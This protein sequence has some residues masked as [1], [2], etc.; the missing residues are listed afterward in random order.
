MYTYHHELLNIKFCIMTHAWTFYFYTC[1][2]WMVFLSLKVFLH[3]QM[4]LVKQCGCEWMVLCGQ[5]KLKLLRS[6]DVALHVHVVFSMK[7]PCK[8]SLC[9]FTS[10][11]ELSMAIKLNFFFPFM[12]ICGQ[13]WCLFINSCLRSQLSQLSQV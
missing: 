6:G 4:Q 13:Y 7:T 12:V 11:T 10:L 1:N 9:M 8:Y 2:N 3:M 5:E